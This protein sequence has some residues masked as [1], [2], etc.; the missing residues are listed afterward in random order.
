MIVVLIVS[1]VVTVSAVKVLTAVMIRNAV[2]A[3]EEYHPVAASLNCSHLQKWP[4]PNL[5]KSV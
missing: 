5:Q 1:V 2:I 3:V 4:Q